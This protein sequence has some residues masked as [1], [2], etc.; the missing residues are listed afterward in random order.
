[1]TTSLV[2]TIMRGDHKEKS[3]GEV[4]NFKLE[5]KRALHCHP[6][7]SGT[8]LSLNARSV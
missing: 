3:H 4:R 7:G 5:E 2:I 8:F 1:M 6:G